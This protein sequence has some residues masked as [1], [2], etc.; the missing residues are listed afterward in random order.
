MPEVASRTRSKGDWGGEKRRGDEDENVKETICYF[1]RAARSCVH[2]CT[3]ASVLIAAA[4]ASN[5]TRLISLSLAE[6]ARFRSE[7]GRR[8]EKEKKKK[9]VGKR[10]TR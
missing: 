6:S 9:K 10:T 4:N 7:D 1:Q 3:R 2:T 5:F 8:K